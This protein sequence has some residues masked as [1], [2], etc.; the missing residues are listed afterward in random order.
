M[1]TRMDSEQL[2][3][4][5]RQLLKREGQT[6]MA[7]LTVAIDRTERMVDRY[8]KGLASPNPKKVYRIALACGC[9][10]IEALEF[11]KACAIEQATAA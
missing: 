10:H 11:V 7:K 8:V 1:L 6:G 2:R 9:N 4:L 3:K 5:M